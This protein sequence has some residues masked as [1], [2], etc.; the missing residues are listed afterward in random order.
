MPYSPFDEF[1][2]NIQRIALHI[3]V[4]AFRTKCRN[5]ALIDADEFIYFPNNK[6]MNIELFCKNH[7]TISMKSRILTNKNNDDILDN[8]ILKLAKYI[9]EE[10]YFKVIL[11]TS[12]IHKNEFINLPH[13]HVS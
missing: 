7:S 2:N 8:N 1:W 12:R 3:G 10:K 9:G 6:N 11:D 4:N 13:E 5:I